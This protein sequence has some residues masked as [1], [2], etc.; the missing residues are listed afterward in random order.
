VSDPVGDLRRELVAAA[1]RQHMFVAEGT[2][3]PG[4]SAPR[5]RWLLA[6][7]ALVVVATA[8]LFITTPWNS[9]PSFLEKAEA[10]LAPRAGM[11]LHQK[12]DVTITSADLACTVRHRPNEIWVDGTPPYRFRAYLDD[13]EA[14]PLGSPR[15]V[16]CSKP[17]TAEFGGTLEPG[18]TVQFVPPNTLRSALT[19]QFGSQPDPVRQLRGAIAAGNAHDEGKATLDGRT[20]ERIR[21]DDFSVCPDAPGCSHHPAYAYV[22]PETFHP[23]QLVS[24]HNHVIHGD[25]SFDFVLRTL[26]FEYLSRTDSNLA[27]TDIRKQHPNA[28]EG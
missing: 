7:V 20:V 4:L 2:H 26:T 15:R 24:M 13:L 28:A 8:A 6:S 9:S 19:F 25:F 10:A 22:D 16:L 12:W 23:V 14:L 18:R 11:I 27:L 17:P 3:Q 21:I 1:E 5:A